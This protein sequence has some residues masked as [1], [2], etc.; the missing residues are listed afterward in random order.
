MSKT[1][2]VSLDESVHLLQLVKQSGLSHAGA[3]RMFRSGLLSD[4]CKAAEDDCLPDRLDFRFLVGPNELPFLIEVDYSATTSQ[5]VDLGKYRR[6]Y[7]N[8]DI[9][10]EPQHRYDIPSSGRVLVRI[11]LFRPTVSRRIDEILAEMAGKSVRPVDCKAFLTLLIQEPDIY[12]HGC[13]MCLGSVWKVSGR[14]MGE[15]CDAFIEAGES[16][17]IHKEGD[18]FDDSKLSLYRRS[19][20][21]ECEFENLNHYLFP[22]TTT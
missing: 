3:Q 9:H 17:I 22:V 8:D 5:L 11:K 12:K 1:K 15:R 4:L 6:I 14:G 16:G 2:A 10:A 20:K 7:D 19:C 18:R 21:D 13:L